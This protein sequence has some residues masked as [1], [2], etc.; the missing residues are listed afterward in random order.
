MIINVPSS[1]TVSENNIIKR[2]RVI[3][4]EFIDPA[5]GAIKKIIAD[6]DGTLQSETEMEYDLFGNLAS[7]TYPGNP[8]VQRMSYH[9]S[10]DKIMN[11]YVIEIKDV[12]GYKSS[13]EYDF[14][15]DAVLKT[16]DKAGN[17]T[18]YLYDNAGRLIRIAGPKEIASSS[19]PFTIKFEYYP[20]LTAKQ[21]NKE[22]EGITANNFM[23]FAITKHFDDF[24][25]Y[26]NTIDTKTFSDG[27]GRVVQVKKD[28]EINLS[29]NRLS[30]PDYKEAMSVSG[31]VVYDEYGRAVLQFQPGWEQKIDN[32]NNFVNTSSTQYF[33]EISYDE[34]D[35]PVKSMDAEENVSITSYFISNGRLVT[36]NETQKDNNSWVI[37]ESYKNL[38]GNVVKTNGID[39]SLG[40]SITTSFNYNE[41][42]ELGSYTDAKQLTSAYTYDKLGRKTSFNHPDQGLTSYHYDLSGNLIKLYTA[43]LGQNSYIEYKYDH[44]RLTNVIFPPDGGNQNVSDVSY[45]YGGPDA[46]NGAGRIIGQTDA[47][48]SQVFTYGN[49]GE[50][51]TIDRIVVSPDPNYNYLQFTMSFAYDSWNRIQKITYPDR[52]M[53]SYYY[54]LGGNLKQI[55]YSL[56]SSL[57]NYLSR[58]EYDHFEQKT[59]EKYANGVYNLF[60]YSPE[61]RRLARIHVLK[62]RAGTD[63]PT[64]TEYLKTDFSFDKIRN[65]T[66]IDNNTAPVNELMGK[67]VHSYRYDNF[68]RLTYADGKFTGSKNTLPNKKANYTLQMEYSSTGEINKKVQVHSENGLGTTLNTYAHTYTHEANSHR[69]EKITNQNDAREY[70]EYDNNGNLTRSER[71]NVVTTL[72][73]DEANRLKMVTNPHFVQHYL[74]D[75]SG[76]RV[77]KTTGRVSEVFVNGELKHSE[78]RS[79]GYTVYP[80]GYLTISSTGIYTKHYYM[81]TQRLV[82]RPAVYTPGG[83]KDGSEPELASLKKTQQADLS[84]LLVKAGYGEMVYPSSY[85]TDEDT[86][87]AEQPL[88]YFHPDHLGSSTLLT[89]NNGNPYQFFL[90]LPFGETMTE[91]KASGTYTNP[92]R[93]N[94]KELDD[95]T[96][97]YYYGARYYNPRYS[98]W[99]G[100]DPMVE[101]YAG[102]S[103]YAY[104]MNNPVRLIDPDGKEPTPNEA[105]ALI[106]HINNYFKGD[107]IGDWKLDKSY[108][109]RNQS[110]FTGG[111]YSRIKDDGD[112]E[113]AFVTRGSDIDFSKLNRESTRKDWENNLGQLSGA[114]EQYKK[115]VSIARK[116][117]SDIKDELTFVGQSLGGGLASANALATG[118]RGIT[119]NAAGL[120]EATLKDLSLNNKSANI[121]AWIM[122]GEIAD[123]LQSMTPGVNRAYGRRVE[124]MPSLPYVPGISPPL[125]AVQIYQRVQNHFIEAFDGKFEE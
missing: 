105:I 23:P 20:T 44:N 21:D 89:D 102:I 37:N 17:E 66:T 41:I 125:K 93:F 69:L 84:N 22:M 72:Q 88:Y 13:A 80:N 60:D 31:M 65:I 124:L 122:K 8:D 62:P 32:G 61:L 24:N 68:N 34:L 119:F 81:G 73:W 76:E 45:T 55:K 9:Y 50:V 12:L 87:R 18:R 54:D 5:T 85:E 3:P 47:T 1:I 52:E 67:F 36:R 118:R 90:N 91:Q 77:L 42:G 111:M 116:L 27:L 58:I 123:Y 2:S 11:K 97:L 15:F 29:P 39:Q 107:L 51:I 120:S 108:D 59:V 121:T 83:W 10:Y 99:L 78:V 101:K 109:D 57:G 14:K 7:I 16:I 33:T 98:V 110:G 26:G 48:G 117:S 74:Y 70:F 40:E 71:D 46:G 35:R 30:N 96:G 56:G 104:C 38:S 82:S 63:P 106:K 79:D 103:P 86:T 43:N 75:A 94:G 49:M 100:V 112:T 113:Y 92:Y 19:D 64:Y 53:V 6:I 28:I 115:S 114:T 25:N 95:E 4:A